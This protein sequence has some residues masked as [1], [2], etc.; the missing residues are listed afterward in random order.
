MDTKKLLQDSL[1]DYYKCQ[2]EKYKANLSVLLSMHVGVAE[3]P[4]ILETLDEQFSKLAEADEKLEMLRKH[5]YRELS[6]P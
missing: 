3:H 6:S 1:E 5:F 4:D 2:V